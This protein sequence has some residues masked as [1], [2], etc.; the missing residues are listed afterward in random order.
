MSIR[1]YL[2]SPETY[3]QNFSTFRNLLIWPSLLYFFAATLWAL[4]HE[5]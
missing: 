3:E 1:V 2:S 5:K 4:R